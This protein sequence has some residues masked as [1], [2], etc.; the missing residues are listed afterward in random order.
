MLLPTAPH[1]Q[2]LPRLVFYLVVLSFSSTSLCS[3]AT[4][5]FS[6]VVNDLHSRVFA[7]CR[8]LLRPKPMFLLQVL[9]SFAFRRYKDAFMVCSCSH[10][11]C[12]FVAPPSL[13]RVALF[14][15]YGAHVG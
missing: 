15:V 3:H 5:R 14:V 4:I 7:R 11:G 12:R 10:F 9:R 2:P 8:L 1:T 13:I 6:F